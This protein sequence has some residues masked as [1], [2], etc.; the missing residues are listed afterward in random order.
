MI[1]RTGLLV[2]LALSTPGC[3][4]SQARWGAVPDTASS[5]ERI[6]PNPNWPPR[7]PP[8]QHEA[9]VSG[10]LLYIARLVLLDWWPQESMPREGMDPVS[11][12]VASPESYRMDI[13]EEVDKYVV[14]ITF[15]AQWRCGMFVDTDA[16][17]EISKDKL[18]IISKRPHDGPPRSEEAV[19]GAAPGKSD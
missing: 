18:E 5:P 8:L 11:R 19:D 4:T 15:I 9:S 7:P 2:M 14:N 13:R 17:Y 1:P 16:T 6:V 10:N 12:C 3:A